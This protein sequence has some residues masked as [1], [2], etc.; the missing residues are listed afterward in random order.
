MG[1]G[2]RTITSSNRSMGISSADKKV[3]VTLDLCSFNANPK[4]L[5]KV[6]DESNLSIE[7][8]DELIVPKE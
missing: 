5:T 6:E 8:E 7:E 4:T 3:G 2:A 1:L